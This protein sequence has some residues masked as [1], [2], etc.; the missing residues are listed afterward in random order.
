MSVYSRRPALVH[1]GV[2]ITLRVRRKLSEIKPDPDDVDLARAYSKGAS[3]SRPSV[4]LE[5]IMWDEEEPR[6]EAK[7]VVTTPAAAPS[8]PAREVQPR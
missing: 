7:P 6:A 1:G 4:P 2:P 3:T 5:D 8:A